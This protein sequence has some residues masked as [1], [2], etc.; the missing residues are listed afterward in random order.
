MLFM[1][2][3]TIVWLIGVFLIEYLKNIQWIRNLVNARD[4]GPS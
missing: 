4:P 3:H 1:G 2:I